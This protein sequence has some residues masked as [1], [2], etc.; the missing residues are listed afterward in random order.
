[1]SDT[2]DTTSGDKFQKFAG[3][4]FDR[5]VKGTAQMYGGK[6]MDAEKLSPDQEL[7][8]W[9]KPTS[10]AALKALELG[11]TDADAEQA[12]VLWAHAMRGQAKII[13]Q[14][15]AGQGAL[16]EQIHETLKSQGLTDEMIA[17]ECRKHAY[18][19]GKQNGHNDPKEE[20]AYHKRMAEK[21][22]ARRAAQAGE[23][24]HAATEAA[25]GG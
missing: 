24:S 7:E 18:N 17:A 19:L 5:L 11:G 10:P 21:A 8:L 14:Q 2:N 16:P 9:M 12:N 4:W 3:E 25:P 15:M 20:V 13:R 6:A 23:V 1:M 22:A